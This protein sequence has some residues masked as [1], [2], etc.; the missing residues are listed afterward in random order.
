MSSEAQVARPL[1]QGPGLKKQGVVVLQSL[2]IFFFGSIELIFRSGAGVVT[3]VIVCAVLYGGVRFG[4]KGTTYV[5]VVTPPLAFAAT[6]LFYAL[7]RDGI[8]IS[9]LGIDFIASLASIAP[10]LLLSAI[11]GWFVFLNEKAKS[12]PSKN[13]L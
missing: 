11:Y 4:R 8:H 9:R 3:G 6:V 2:F 10:Y 12:K 13:S 5:S 1:I 7:L